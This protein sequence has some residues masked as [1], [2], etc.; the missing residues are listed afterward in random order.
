[1]SQAQSQ[2]QVLKL[3]KG[4]LY[5]RDYK[6]AENPIIMIFFLLQKNSMFFFLFVE[7]NV[8]LIQH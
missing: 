6:E 5:C 4:L 7:I 3:T 2:E 8:Q 1:M